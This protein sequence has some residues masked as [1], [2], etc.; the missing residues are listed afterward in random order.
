M[1]ITQS[2][3]CFILKWKNLVKEWTSQHLHYYIPS[4]NFYNYTVPSST[5][6]FSA[7]HASTNWENIYTRTQTKNKILLFP[8]SSERAG[9]VYI[10]NLYK[11]GAP[12]LL[13]VQ[14]APSHWT[15]DLSP[16][17]V[18]A[19]SS[20]PTTATASTCTYGHCDLPSRF[21]YL[22]LRAAY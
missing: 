20:V 8:L 6:Q 16:L 7:K 14:R 19:R 17:E 18:I 12:I 9:S 2:E 11:Y 4:G 13:G 22:I 1:V 15:S 3:I 21:C 10:C 5:C